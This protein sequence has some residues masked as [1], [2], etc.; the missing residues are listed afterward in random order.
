MITGPAAGGG[1]GQ[2]LGE[3]VGERTDH[4]RPLLHG[5]AG[6]ILLGCRTNA[7]DDRPGGDRRQAWGGEADNR[8]TFGVGEQRE[9][10]RVDARPSRGIAEH[11]QG[12]LVDDRAGVLYRDRDGRHGTG[13]NLD[14]IALEFDY[15][16]H[17]DSKSRLRP[18]GR[19]GAEGMIRLPERADREPARIP[20][21]GTN[22]R[23][24]TAERRFGHVLSAR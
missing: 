9:R 6:R 20:R 24:C 5:A 3:G 2:Q 21:T 22:S 11:L 7:E 14:R 8:L 13:D 17:G 10:R 1:S 12:E 19:E 15:R 16:T 23:R 18:R 4:K